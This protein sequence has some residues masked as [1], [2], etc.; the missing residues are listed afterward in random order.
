MKCIRGARQGEPGSRRQ[1]MW[2]RSIVRQL[3]ELSRISSHLTLSQHHS[4]LF[5]PVGTPPLVLPPALALGAALDSGGASP[6]G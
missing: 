4:F 2:V 3:P 5:P 6:G 1:M